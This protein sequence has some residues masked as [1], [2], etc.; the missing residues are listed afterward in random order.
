MFFIM[1]LLAIVITISILDWWIIPTAPRKLIDLFVGFG[2][3][4]VIGLALLCPIWGVSYD[5]YLDCKTFFDGTKE[6][7]A[8]AVTMYSNYAEIDLKSAAWTDFKYKGYQENVA[9]FISSLRQKIVNY[10]EMIISKRVMGKNLFFSWLIVEPDDDMLVIRMT[11]NPA[12]V[13]GTQQP[14]VNKGN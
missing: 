2:I 5:T 6:Q 1:S 11:S 10:N 7:Y 8:S 4:S 14:L 13:A 3:A 12:A 9:G